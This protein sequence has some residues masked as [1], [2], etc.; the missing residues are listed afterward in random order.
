MNAD[1]RKIFILVGVKIKSLN[2]RMLVSAKC[3]FYYL[4]DKRN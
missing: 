1:F 4:N 3:I 2:H